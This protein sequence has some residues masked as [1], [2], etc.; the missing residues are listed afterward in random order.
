LHGFP[1]LAVSW[2]HQFAALGDMWRMIA[3]DMRGYG[4]TDAPPRTRDYGLRHLVQDVIDLLDELGAPHAHLVGHDWG[5]AVAW[6]VAQVHGD[7]LHTLS[8]L[9]CPPVEIMKRHVVDPDQLRRSWYIF[10][11]QLPFLA[12]RTFRK[13]PATMIKRVFRGG[14]VNKAAFTDAELEP[15]IDQVRDLGLPGLEYYRAN[16]SLIPERPRP[17]TVPTRLIWGVGDPALG[18][19]FADPRHYR[20]WVRKLDV[21]TI[22]AALSGHWVQQEAPGEVNDALRQH[23]SLHSGRSDTKTP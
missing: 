9:N 17:I 15:Y 5:G 19:Q 8:V 3:P 21:V 14:A 13:D 1:E 12:E 4:G 23:W 18:P 2:R 7:R 16:F 11:F 22:P 10:F 6:R 20:D